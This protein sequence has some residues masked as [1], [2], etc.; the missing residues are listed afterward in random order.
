VPG[1][2]TTVYIGEPTL[3][4]LREW[5]ERAG[6]NLASIIS[7]VVRYLQCQGVDIDQVMET[8]LKCVGPKPLPIG[9]E[10]DGGSAGARRL[11]L[12]GP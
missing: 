9:V 4:T 8:V 11:K 3:S 7:I 2:G 5:S 10:E 1:K 6:L 12:P